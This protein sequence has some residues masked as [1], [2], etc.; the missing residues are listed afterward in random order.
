MQDLRKFKSAARTAEQITRTALSKVGIDRHYVKVFAIGFNKTATTSIDTLFGDLGYRARHHGV[1]WRPKSAHRV[2]WKYQAFSDG[3]PED[4]RK[5][6]ENFPKSRFILNT[7]D[8]LEWLDSRY[9]HVKLKQANGGHS[10]PYWQPTPEAMEAWIIHRN[11]YHLEV[12]EYFANRPDDL[13]IVNFIRDP[14]AARKIADFLGRSH[15]GEKPYTRSTQKTREK[16][17]LKNAEVIKSALRRL[18]VDETE[19]NYDLYFPSLTDS[20]LPY[21]TSLTD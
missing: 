21:D 16:G 15:D 10:G 9:Q 11:R 2:H 13:L 7:R 12:L 1:A 19:W 14:M 4:F 8:P 18:N 20:H 5:L 17:Q 3:T 6:D